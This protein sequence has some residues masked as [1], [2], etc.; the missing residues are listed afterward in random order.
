MKNFF[1]LFGIV[2]VFAAAGFSLMGCGSPTDG[3]EQGDVFYGV[4]EDGTYDAIELT[5]ISQGRAARAITTGSLYTIK[6]KGAIISTGSIDLTG[7]SVTFTSQGGK[8]FTATLDTGNVLIIAAILLDNNTIIVI[9]NLYP[10]VSNDGK[11][12]SDGTWTDNYMNIVINGNHF[13]TEFLKA[14][15][16][17]YHDPVGSKTWGT[18]MFTDKYIFRIIEGWSGYEGTGWTVDYYRLFNIVSNSRTQITV[19]DHDVGVTI[20]F[21]KIL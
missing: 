3:G 15:S 17:Y 4:A 14:G 10:P 13:S 11:I 7:S 8:I 18:F 19:Y 16:S 12:I 5:I 21:N 20:V 9:A 1:K 2:T 6:R